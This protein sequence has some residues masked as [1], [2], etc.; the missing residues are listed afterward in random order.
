MQHEDLDLVIV[1][2]ADPFWLQ[3]DDESWRH[4]TGIMRMVGNYVASLPTP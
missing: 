2:T 3:H 1:T 4:E